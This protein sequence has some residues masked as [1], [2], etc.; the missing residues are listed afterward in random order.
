MLEFGTQTT[1]KIPQEHPDIWLLKSCASNLMVSL[2]I[3]LPWESSDMNAC[4]VEDHILEEIEEKLESTYWLNK[5]K[6][7]ELIFHKDGPLRQPI[8]SID[9]F[10]ENH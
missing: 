9:L 4:L 5:Y 8:S 3:I 7:R 6:L 1:Q 10:R 2:S